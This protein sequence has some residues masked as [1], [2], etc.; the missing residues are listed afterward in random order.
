MAAEYIMLEGNHQVILCERGIKTFE[1]QTRNTLDLNAVPVIKHLSHLPVMVDPSHGTGSW[2]MVPPM[3]RAAVAAG[4]DGLLIEVHPSPGDALS[5]G[6]QSLTP[7]N[8]QRLVQ[9]VQE[10]ARAVGRSLPGVVVSG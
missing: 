6:Q 2:W 7:E 5:D 9:E 10:V 8:F 1:T 3:S 4:A